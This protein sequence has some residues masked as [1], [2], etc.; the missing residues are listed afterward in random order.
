MESENSQVRTSVIATEA[1]TAVATAIV[2]S[3]AITEVASVHSA[4]ISTVLVSV[5]IIKVM[6]IIVVNWPLNWRL[7][8]KTKSSAKA[9]TNESSCAILPS[10][11]NLQSPPSTRC[12]APPCQWFARY[13]LYFAAQCW[14]KSSSDNRFSARRKKISMKI[15]IRAK[16]FRKKKQNLSWMEEEKLNLFFIQ[17]W[18]NYLENNFP[19]FPSF[20]SV[21]TSIAVRFFDQNE[22]STER[23]ANCKSTKC[24]RM[25]SGSQKCFFFPSFLFLF[26]IKQTQQEKEAKWMIRAFVTS[27]LFLLSRH[28]FHRAVNET[29]TF[30]VP[31]KQKYYERLKGEGKL[32]NLSPVN[33]NFPSNSTELLEAL[34]ISTKIQLRFRSFLH[35]A[36]QL[37]NCNILYVSLF[38]RISLSEKWNWIE[39][40]WWLCK[41]RKYK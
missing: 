22:A 28:R 34:T 17:S 32:I 30:F 33:R 26:I 13:D 36:Q 19:S 15:M 14:R 37:P 31:D 35:G 23:G 5:D 18:E 9:S 4:P 27:F 29:R 25:K 10:S 8:R 38:A 12:I 11:A 41:K 16:M 7:F 6:W 1:S 24:N 40:N 20:C 39:S 2:T 21:W 3:V